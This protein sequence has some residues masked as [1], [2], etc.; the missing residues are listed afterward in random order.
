MAKKNF[1]KGDFVFEGD[2][3]STGTNSGFNTSPAGAD[4]QVQ[5]NNS[6]AFGGSSSFTWSE[7]LKEFKADGSVQTNA[8]GADKDFLHGD[9]PTSTNKKFGFDFGKGTFFSG[10]L[11]APAAVLGTYGF[12]SGK[13]DVTITNRGNFAS[14]FASSGSSLT[15]TNTGSSVIGYAYNSGS[16]TSSGNGSF[17]GGYAYG[18]TISSTS[19]G[20]FAQG[21]SRYSSIVASDLGAFAQG[22]AYSSGTISAATRG[23]FAQG[24]AVNGTIQSG[25]TR[26]QQGAFAQGYANS[27]ATIGA[28]NKGAF[29]QGYANTNNITASGTG[30][31][32]HGF[33][34]SGAIIASAS[35]SVQFGVGTNN[36]ANSLQVG[37]T[38]WLK[39][40]TIWLKEKASEAD[41]TAT[42]GKV[43]VKNTTPAELWFTDDAGTSTKIV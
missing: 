41:A 2:L 1:V 15:A 43:W 24:A 5:Y 36:V 29:A 18:N 23:G 35:N 34:T 28:L 4:T 14:G 6:G 31:F 32:A 27:G 25:P 21:Y 16:I 42:W 39:P 13:G 9:S 33:S 8:S 11:K 26:F 30:A 20:T 37:S 40:N 19:G 10:N 12:L 17:A 38:V 3:T 7:A 22:W